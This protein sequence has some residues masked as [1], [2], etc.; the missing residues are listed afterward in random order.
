[1]AILIL[2]MCFINIAASM[3]DD[4]DYTMIQY[5]FAGFPPPRS[6]LPTPHSPFPIPNS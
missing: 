6:S 1:M 5:C 4:V 3:Y 2:I